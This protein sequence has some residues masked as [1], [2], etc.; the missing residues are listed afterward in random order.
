MLA[1][2]AFM[3]FC[4]GSLFQGP[5]QPL[6]PMFIPLINQSMK[7]ADYKAIYDELS[8]NEPNVGSGLMK[9]RNLLVVELGTAIRVC[10]ASC[11]SVPSEFIGTGLILGLSDS[12]WGPKPTL[13]V[14]GQTIN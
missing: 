7:E 8:V 14:A 12:L 4:L 13:T 5:S 1:S 6:F 9:A 2:T 3:T 11:V 10:L